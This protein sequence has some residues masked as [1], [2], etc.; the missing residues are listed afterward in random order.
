MLSDSVCGQFQERS[1]RPHRLGGLLCNS[2]TV[3]HQVGQ[4]IINAGKPPFTTGLSMA[5]RAAGWI[6]GA[7]VAMAAFASSSSPDIKKI[8]PANFTKNAVFW[9]GCNGQ[10]GRLHDCPDP[11]PTRRDRVPFT[12]GFHSAKAFGV[13]GDSNDIS[14]V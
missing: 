4:T 6:I 9:R 11:S 5:S 1:D 12:A 3:G 8:P 13:I 10:S 2:L 7:T 14:L